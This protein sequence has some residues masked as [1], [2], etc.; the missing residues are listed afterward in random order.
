MKI[1]KKWRNLNLRVKFGDDIDYDIGFLNVVFSYPVYIGF[2]YS[3]T[4]IHTKQYI[5]LMLNIF[6]RYN[7]EKNIKVK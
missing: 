4:F 3:I 1:T 7:V 2:S 5:F 6:Y